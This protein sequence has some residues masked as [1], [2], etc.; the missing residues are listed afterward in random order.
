MAGAF[1]WFFHASPVVV[2]RNA[3]VAEISSVRVE[4]DIGESYSAGAL[5]VKASVRVTV[6][7]RDKLVWVVAQLPSGAVKESEKVYVSSSGTV[8]AVVTDSG[9]VIQWEP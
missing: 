6:S 9:V 1:W 8:F 5:A 2:I 7:G 3:G 4:T